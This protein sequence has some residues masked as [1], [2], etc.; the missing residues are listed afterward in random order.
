M[1]DVERAGEEMSD[2]KDKSQLSDIGDEIMHHSE[3]SP[4]CSLIVPGDCME[5]D[6]KDVDCPECLT[7]FENIKQRRAKVRA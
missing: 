2:N 3:Y 5:E 1:V 7:K 6:L 4:T